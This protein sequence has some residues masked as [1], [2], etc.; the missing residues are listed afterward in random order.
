MEGR[1]VFYFLIYPDVSWQDKIIKLLFHL[2]IHSM[3]S[4]WELMFYVLENIKNMKT[5]YL[6]VSISQASCR[7]RNV[8][9]V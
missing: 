8:K 1:N 3:P 7:N 2:F 6:I 5:Q 4:I 9:F